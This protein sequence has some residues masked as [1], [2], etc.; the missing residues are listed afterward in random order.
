MLTFDDSH[1]VDAL[2][3]G[4][5]RPNVNSNVAASQS[6]VMTRVEGDAGETG[7][8]QAA[9]LNVV[10]VCGRRHLRWRLGSPLLDGSIPSIVAVVAA[11]ASRTVVRWR[12]TSAA[13]VVPSA[14]ALLLLGTLTLKQVEAG[15]GA[16]TN[17][18]A[19]ALLEIILVVALALVLLAFVVGDQAPQQ[20]LLAQ[21][22]LLSF[23]IGQN[24]LTLD[25]AHVHDF[26]FLGVAG[27][28]A[29]DRI[30]ILFVACSLAG[31]GIGAIVGIGFIHGGRAL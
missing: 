8:A 2:L 1:A 14:P 16:R 17:L 18:L 29:L 11:A 19:G 15:L 26:P 5:I 22:L 21:P 30:L 23:T 20:G 10:Q 3:R 6:L 27:E 24:L 4:R 9:S 7:T 28:Q 12:T 25:L 13:V 31:G